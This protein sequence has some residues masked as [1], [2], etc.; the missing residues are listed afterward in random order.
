MMTKILLYPKP[1]IVDVPDGWEKFSK[2]EKENYCKDYCTSDPVFLFDA[3]FD[4]TTPEMV[5]RLENL[6]GRAK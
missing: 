4:L 6:F 3:Y 1:H 5:K 2:E